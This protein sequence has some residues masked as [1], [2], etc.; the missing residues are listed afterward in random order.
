MQAAPLKALAG[1]D[2]RWR[3]AHPTSPTGCARRRDHERLG[4]LYAL[5]F[6]V[7]RLVREDDHA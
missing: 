4:G 7:F 2:A 5:A 3:L 1:F 6:T